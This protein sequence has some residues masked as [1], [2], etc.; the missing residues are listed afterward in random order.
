MNIFKRKVK[1]Q[2]RKD[3]LQQ[4]VA[5]DKHG[6]SI[7]ER[8]INDLLMYLLEALKIKVVE[9]VELP[10]RSNFDAIT[11]SQLHHALTCISYTRQNRVFQA[12]HELYDFIQDNQIRNDTPFSREEITI[13][14]YL[15]YLILKNTRALSDC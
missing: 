11:Q 1:M 15:S 10:S 14:E 12:F 4:L 2:S 13:V 7:S 6:N 5:A 9:N 3:I 8:E